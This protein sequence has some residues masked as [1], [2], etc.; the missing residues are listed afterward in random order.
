MDAEAGSIEVV[1]GRAVITCSI[2]FKALKQKK[3]IGVKLTLS[4]GIWEDSLIR[5]TIHYN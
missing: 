3:E 4:K 1:V 2:A 5:R